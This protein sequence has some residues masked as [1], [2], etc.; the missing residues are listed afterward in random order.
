MAAL[1]LSGLGVREERVTVGSGREAWT[2]GAALAEGGRSELI[3]RA[4]DA[5]RLL[6]C[7]YAD[8]VVARCVRLGGPFFQYGH[9]LT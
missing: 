2:L 6:L 9:M 3:A 5:V 1:L 8:R 7:C 4:P